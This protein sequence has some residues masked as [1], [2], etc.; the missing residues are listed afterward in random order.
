MLRGILFALLFIVVGMIASSLID[1]PRMSPAG[2][3]EMG[4]PPRDRATPPGNSF[5][6]PG[7]AWFCAV[8]PALKGWAIF[9]KTPLAGAGVGGSMRTWDRA[10]GLCS[11]ASYLHCF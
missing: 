4:F 2:T 7:L 10:K 8:N 1:P 11:E 9:R 5:V 3:K 6:P